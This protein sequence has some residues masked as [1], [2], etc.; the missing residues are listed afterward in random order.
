[1]QLTTTAWKWLF[2]LAIAAAPSPRA[3]ETG[4][5]WPDGAG[6]RAT[7]AAPFDGSSIEIG[8]SSRVAGAIDS[9]TWKGK[10]FVDHKDHGRELQSATAFFGKGECFNPTEAGSADDSVG[11]RSTSRLLHLEARGNV[12]R[13]DSQMA[14]WL[15]PNQRS[16]GCHGA[17]SSVTG[18]LSED[19]LHKTVTIGTEGIPNAI[20]YEATFQIPEE[21]NNG[22]FEVIAAYV[23]A[24][25]A[26]FFTYDIAHDALV[27]VSDGPG[28]QRLPLVFATE[29][30]RYA[31]GVFSPGGEARS[32]APIYSR[33]RFAEPSRADKVNKF[34]CYFL[35]HDVA[36]GDHTFTCY[37]VIGSLEQVRAGMQHLQAQL[38]R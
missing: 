37:V 29:D 13:T 20:Q 35:E 34:S 26:L 1:M 9:L 10:Q 28:Q 12:L 17:V 11:P 27:T 21:R 6:K 3:E 22:G 5:A 8:T 16:A 31:I 4:I 19:K 38:A 33:W 7:I 18:P 32:S 15:G 23:P 25:L 24:D 2:L 36:A 30:H 14:F